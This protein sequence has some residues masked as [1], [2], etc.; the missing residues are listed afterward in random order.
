M[1]CKEVGEQI[2]GTW[3]LAQQGDSSLFCSLLALVQGVPSGIP[4]L[5][6]GPDL[7]VCGVG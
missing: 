5:S 7:C 6:L 2:W 1:Y 4:V 3:Y